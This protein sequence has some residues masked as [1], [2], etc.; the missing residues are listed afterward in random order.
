MKMSF[1]KRI[2]SLLSAVLYQIYTHIPYSILTLIYRHIDYFHYKALSF[3]EF[4]F[5][6]KTYEGEGRN[7]ECY[8]NLW[9]VKKAVGKDFDP[10]C[11]IE[12]GVY[13]GEYV[14]ENYNMPD[15]DTIYTYG[16]YRKNVILKWYGGQTDKKIVP[17]GPYILNADNFKPIQT[18]KK[19]KA[20]FGKI[21]LVF[22]THSSPGFPM[23]YDEDAFIREIEDVA[24]DY[25]NVFVSLFW[26]DVN[27]GRDKIYLDKGYKV[28]CSGTRSDRWFLSRQKDL[29]ELADFSMSN[30]I[31]THVGY[32][33]AMGVP[34]YIFGQSVYEVNG[35][36]E[37]KTRHEIRMREYS[38]IRSAFSFKKPVITDE[39]RRIV[40]YYWGLGSVI[41]ENCR[42]RNSL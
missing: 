23:Q 16:E 30:D 21:L 19:I 41:T 32:S 5:K 39:Q 4:P 24:V 13:F 40:E 20:K 31:G 11:I 18:L 12:H 15:I 17:I 36:K 8:G 9:V 3:Y 6:T 37:E 7:N 42:Y 26:A 35:G 25:D 28:V 14:T 22:P 38:E 33:I 2:T 1:W 27:L 34:H 29:L 10:H